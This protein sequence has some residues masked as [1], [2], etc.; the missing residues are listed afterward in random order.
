MKRELFLP[1]FA[2]TSRTNSSAIY[3]AIGTSKSQ[4]SIYAFVWEQNCEH[5]LAERTPCCGRIAIFP[6]SLYNTIK[7]WYYCRGCKKKTV[8][9]A[10]HSA[11]RATHTH[12]LPFVHIHSRSTIITTSRLK[13]NTSNIFPLA[14]TLPVQSNSYASLE[15]GKKGIRKLSTQLKLCATPP[16]LLVDN[17]VCYLFAYCADKFEIVHN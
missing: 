1:A 6:L 10:A 11:E 7:F 17:G 12:T 9:A 8:S 4:C 13:K 14:Y 5:T 15:D 2:K 3:F 16:M